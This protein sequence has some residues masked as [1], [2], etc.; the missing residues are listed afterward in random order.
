MQP[1][2]PQCM[3][4][5]LL[6]VHMCVGGEGLFCGWLSD[7]NNQPRRGPRRRYDD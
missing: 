4:T 3:E 6:F 1:H 5:I 2:A 7:V